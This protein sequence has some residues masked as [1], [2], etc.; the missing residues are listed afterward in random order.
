MKRNICRLPVGVLSLFGLW[1]LC[2]NVASAAPTWVVNSLNTIGCASNATGFSTTVAGYAGGAERFRTQVDS[3]GLR[4]M[5]EDAGPIG[6]GAFGWHLYSS[7]SGGPTTGAWPIP[8]GQPITV[9]FMF[10]NGAGGPIVY[11]RQV[12]LSQ[13]N[14]GSIVSDVVIL[15]PGSPYCSGF[16]D[17]AAGA[18]Y[19]S[20]VDFLKNRAI[21]TGCASSPTPLY[22]PGDYVTRAQMALFM[23]RLADKLIEQPVTVNALPGALALT[24]LAVDNAICPTAVIPAAQ[25]PRTIVA[26]ANATF[27][28]STAIGAIGTHI[29]YTLDGN[30]TNWNFATPN[31]QRTTP[32]AAYYA[33]A[34]ASAVI[35]VPAGA[36]VKIAIGAFTVSGSAAV[37][38]SRCIVTAAIQS[39][40][41]TSSPFDEQPIVPAP[42]DGY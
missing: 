25:Y 28:M 32:D 22:C 34:S 7:N 18:S 17:V 20:S 6:N 12:T 30:T 4:Y 19:C 23:N 39:K 3:G 26:M 33:T 5:D 1:L 10:I 36:A 21:T 15:G 38:E 27:R 9:N 42:G 14:A 35:Q 31:S 2:V 13:C 11:W 16:T 40:T 37:A 8:A 29:L 41:G 24:A